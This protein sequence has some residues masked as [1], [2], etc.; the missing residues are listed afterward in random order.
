MIGPSST[1]TFAI[2][3]LGCKVNRV[4]SDTLR[5][6]LLARGCAERA[7]ADADIVVVNTC[8]VT[9]E[10]D[11]KVRKAVRRA[12][13]ASSESLVLAT[14]CAVTI[15]PQALAALSPRVSLEPDKSL[16]LE[17]ACSLL[18]VD[19]S[20][21]VVALG[22]GE[23][24]RA[25]VPVKIGDG[26]DNFCAYCII[27]HARGPVRSE[28]LR[29][30]VA[31]VEAL[32]AAR[33]SEIVLT[34]VN[35]GRYRDP[36]SGDGLPALVRALSKTG[37]KRIRLSSIEPPDLTKELLAALVDSGVAAPH[38]HVPLQSGSDSVLARMERKYSTDE[39]RTIVSRAREAFSGLALTTDVIVGFPGESDSEAEKTMRF[40]EEVGFSKLHVFRYSA[41][42]GTPAASMG[43][44]VPPEVKA[45]R[46][47]SLRDLGVRLRSDF[48]SSHLGSRL[49]VLVER[50]RETESGPIATGTSGEYLDV[51]FR[52]PEGTSHG[53]LVCVERPLGIS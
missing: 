13:A 16:L 19:A 34:G 22:A 5:A 45:A 35:L 17:H 23:G 18:G 6:E 30:I 21:P 51:T 26:C 11:A 9:Q 36:A 33:T 3:T 40:C 29:D 46:A 15:A 14:G 47:A 10:A 24:F 27:S 37:V 28:P 12:L 25:R 38:L 43:G 8:T 52:A 48:I 41:R 31:G 2:K 4:E 49:E 39:Y 20:A 1:P 42:E 53:D 32:V 50:V 44:Q 7:E